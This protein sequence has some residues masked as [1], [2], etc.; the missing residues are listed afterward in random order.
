IGHL[1]LQFLRRLAR[2]GE[3]HQP[4]LEHVG[5]EI[6]EDFADRGGNVLGRGLVLLHAA[7]ASARRLGLFLVVLVI[8]VVAVIIGGLR[9]FLVLVLRLGRLFLVLVLRLGRLFLVLVLVLF[10]LGG[11]NLRFD[12]CDLRA[13]PRRFGLGKLGIKGGQI[14]RRISGCGRLRSC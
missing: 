2:I 10:G 4:T 9:L 13:V 6:A 7:L 11:L 5:G 1:G 14:H 12:G 8:I 3:R